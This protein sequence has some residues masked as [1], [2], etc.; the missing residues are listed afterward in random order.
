[1][2]QLFQ[3]FAARLSF[4][5]LLLTFLIFCCIGIVFDTYSRSREEKQAILYTHSLLDNMALKIE[6]RLAA[7]EK[8]VTN[9][10]PKIEEARQ[11]PEQ[12]SGLVEQMVWNDSLMMGGCV[13]FEPHYFPE[14]GEYFM[15][16][17]WQD[18]KKNIR[19]KRLGGKE[20]N[21]FTQKWYSEAKQTAR[22]I[23]S[24]PY[25]DEGGGNEMM[26]TY[27]FPLTDNRGETYAVLTADI[28]LKE[29]MADIDNLRPYKDSYTFLLSRKG[30]Y[31]AHWDLNMIL[32]ETIFSRAK[33]KNN[34]QM[35][36]VGTEMVHGRR[37]TAQIEVEGKRAL[38]FYTPIAHVGWSLCN[39][40]HYGTIMNTLASAALT[41][42]SILLGGIII[43]FIA[44]RWIVKHETK[45][46]EVFA[47]AA[48]K[49][50]AGHF[51][52][53]LPDV[54]SRDEMRA[55]HD[56]FVFMQRSLTRYI[57]DLKV[58]MATNERIE[59]ELNIACAI[60]MGMLPKTFPAYPER[61]EIDLFATLVSAREV[62]GDLYD[63]RVSG[64]KL[65]FAIGDVSGKGIPASLVMAVTQSMFRTISS[66]TDSPG[67]IISA[68]NRTIAEKNDRNM[69]VT[70]FVGVFDMKT[71]ELSFCNAG[72]NAPLL[73]SA[74]GEAIFLKVKPNL[75]VGLI[76]DFDYQ[77]E[78][79]R[80]EVGSRLLLYTD[81]VSEAENET[82]LLFSE[83]RIL[84]ESA[85]LSVSDTTS[86]S[87]VKHL[88]QAV[89]K[90]AGKAEQSD[91]IT[92]LALA[93]KGTPNH[94]DAENG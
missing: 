31:L 59:N 62:G 40:A 58:S 42:L 83:Q 1:M 26:T 43:L 3:S 35:A 47:A 69:F 82:H 76:G 53:P 79:I 52:E 60:Q 18:S 33:I 32:N 49:I 36:T 50:A 38:A 89:R 85:S 8:S 34:P 94:P 27:S 88:L 81:G 13:A 64:D 86:E 63:F 93:Y 74:Q 90:H 78:S 22:G 41:M 75:P 5:I 15:E 19:H 61:P 17:V 92:L 25:Y 67:H 46:L 11:H 72:H 6:Q 55:L 2:K 68:V 51:N 37:G 66:Q 14:I 12:M 24:E 80:L 28:S 4:Y 56:S 91:D 65:H 45:P 21:Y 29:L 23:W 57:E 48:H 30:V 84:D 20:Y 10:V 16:Y 44:I 71:G 73:I 9:T 77:E 87:L 54:E 70:M 39:I 7:V